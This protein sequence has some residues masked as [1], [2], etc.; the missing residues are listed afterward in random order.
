MKVNPW[1][2]LEEWVESENELN[3][4]INELFESDLSPETQAKE[5]LQYL[6]VNYDLP[7]T[8][9]D[10]PDRAWE[11]AGGSLY[12]PISLHELVGQLKFVDPENSDPRYLVLNAAYMICN[13]LVIDMGPEMDSYLGDEI[14]QGLGYRGDQVL[15]AE[16]IPIKEGESWFDKGCSFFIKD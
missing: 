3:L 14:L 13:K 10:I 9:S 2:S 11:D 5:L 8:P 4:K 6:V 1:P 15:D 16:L 12:Q 7:Q